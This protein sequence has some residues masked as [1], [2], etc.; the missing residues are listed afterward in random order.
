MPLLNLFFATSKRIG[1]HVF[2]LFFFFILF[3]LTEISES[4]NTLLFQTGNMLSKPL[5]LQKK[6]KKII[7]YYDVNNLK[8]WIF[9]TLYLCTW[10][11][12]RIDQ[13]PTS[14]TLML[15][16]LAIFTQKSR[17]CLHYSC[18]Q[19]EIINTHYRRKEFEIRFRRCVT[20]L[21][22]L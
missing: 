12:I 20:K 18:K 10:W 22:I 11:F 4:F 15:L 17:K 9:I 19:N 6:K 5:R 13:L 16:I 1:F 7:N 14:N 21:Y 2:F 8:L 3:F